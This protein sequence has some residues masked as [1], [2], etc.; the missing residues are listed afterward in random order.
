MIERGGGKEVQRVVSSWYRIS[1][2]G[3]TGAQTPKEAEAY[4]HLSLPDRAIADRVERR[5]RKE[6]GLEAEHNEG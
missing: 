3:S 2:A 6:K 1:E 5:I 4:R